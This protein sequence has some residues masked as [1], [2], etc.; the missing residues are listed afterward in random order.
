MNPA[1][2]SRRAGMDPIRRKA[3]AVARATAWARCSVNG[4]AFSGG[5]PVRRP[6]VV[7]VGVE[8]AQ[9]AIDPASG[10]GFVSLELEVSDA[11]TFCQSPARRWRHRAT[12]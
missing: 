9:A 7:G 6:A 1:C 3:T 8:E 5:C 12:Q 10:V 4:R 2:P 11:G